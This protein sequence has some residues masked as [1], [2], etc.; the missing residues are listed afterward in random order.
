[1]RR[2]AIALAILLFAAAA[3]QSQSPAYLVKEINETPKPD[4]S[5]PDDFLALGNLAIFT[6]NDSQGNAL[7]VWRSDGSE[8]GTFLLGAGGN[9]LAIWNGRVWFT[10]PNG[11][12]VSSDGIQ[13]AQP[14][15]LPAGVSPYALMPSGPW[16]YFAAGDYLWRTD[17]TA[18]GTSKA[19]TETL[20][21]VPSTGT[22]LTGQ[23][24][25]FT[26][27]TPGSSTNSL[28]RAGAQVE[29]I[30]T[31]PAGTVPRSIGS[32]GSLVYIDLLT[33]ASNA[34]TLWR[35]DGTAAG[36]FELA[37]MPG[38]YVF[39]APY[40]YFTS[41][42][43]VWRSDGS[44]AGTGPLHASGFANG[45]PSPLGA[46]PDG[47][48]IVS[49]PA[50]APPNMNYTGLWSF[51]GMGSTFLANIPGGRPLPRTLGNLIVLGA[52]R[53]LWR[54]DGTVGG[55]YKLTGP[56]PTAG[57]PYWSFGVAGTSLFFNGEDAVHGRELW[58]TDGTVPNTLLVKDVNAATHPSYPTV[59]RALNGGVLFS[60]IGSGPD[61]P[62]PQRDLWFSDGT[63]AGTRKVLE[64][65]FVG[66][67]HGPLPCGRRAYFQHHS[68]ATGYELWSTD[69][70][71]LGTAIVKDIHPGVTG[72]EANSSSPQGFVC[73]DDRVLFFAGSATGWG[74]WRSD[75][76]AAGTVEVDADAGGALTPFGRGVFYGKN[77]ELWVS[78][79]TPGGTRSVT[80]LASLSSGLVVAGYHAWFTTYDNKLWRTDGT[81]A[82]TYP[83]P[84]PGSPFGLFAFGDRVVIR[85]GGDAPGYWS[86][87]GGAVTRFDHQLSASGAWE[88]FMR[89]LNGR[90]YYNVP[91]LRS[92]DGFTS[93]ATG[94][95][96]ADTLLAVA[97]GRLYYTQW[98]FGLPLLE[99]DGTAGGT[100]A[101]FDE[102]SSEA[103]ASGG[104]L[105]IGAK[106]LYAYD[107]PVTSTSI[108]PRTLPAGSGGQVVIH[109]RGFVA[110]V[111]VTVDKTPVSV[112]SVTATAIT[113]TAPPR[114]AGTYEVKLLTGDGREMTTDERLA[115]ACSPLTATIGATPPAVCPLT[116]VQLNG[117]G[118]SR[119]SWFPGTGLD[120]PSSCNPV[121]RAA[122]TTTYTLIVSDANACASTNH[123][124]VTV[125]VKP[126]PVAVITFSPPPPGGHRP[127]GTY[128]ASVP[129]G[130]PGTNYAWTI[131]G[132]AQLVGPA[133][134]RTVTFTTGCAYP[135]LSVIVTSAG[136]SASA[137]VN[138]G[139]S[140][141]I[142]IT[143]ISPFR[144]NAGATITVTGTSFQCV[145][146]VHLYDALYDRDADIPVT[147]SSETSVSFRL[148]ANAPPWAYVWM[149]GPFGYNINHVNYVLIRPLRDAFTGNDI[150]TDILTRNASTS[151]TEERGVSVNG[152]VAAPRP[153]V[154]PG[155]DYTIAAVHE[156]GLEM[157]NADVLWQRTST[158]ELLLQMDR[159]KPGT[160]VARVP[161]SDLAIAAV[162]D[163]D[164]NGFPELILRSTVTG[165]TELWTLSSTGAAV[166]VQPLHGGGNLGW[167]IIG[168]RDFD[169][170]GKS[171]L[172]W[173]D[174]N[175]GM[176]LIWLMNGATIRSSQIVH[177][178]GN[179]DWSIAA[180]GDFDADTKNDI[181][182]RHTPTG[183]TLLWRM[184]GASILQSS[185]VHPGGNLGWTIAGAGDFNGDSKSDIL[186]RESAQGTVLQWQMNGTQ[187]T[188]SAVVFPALDPA[189]KIESPR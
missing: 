117:G 17:G 173:R 185:V 118:G 138:L 60:A 166:T 96:D 125:T 152:A 169:G 137:S 46:L 120:N 167:K 62:S 183:M 84:L 89:P 105:F 158:R 161:A 41:G 104:R 122:T 15:P 154:D 146:T 186:W 12:L 171:D 180:L 168:S 110:P 112:V 64:R 22:A 65:V 177:Q 129:D 30:K 11:S 114:Q 165:A 163:H 76:T 142:E 160:V 21:V 187:I 95:P 141:P 101:I 32:T 28:W 24:A 23:S 56:E 159:T 149:S 75:G 35:T 31:F 97:G 40:L 188:K 87:D 66:D 26:V 27:T 94:A 108:A 29:H 33:Y 116:P 14:V 50:V 3:A 37:A 124:T 151:V 61:Y 113:F 57:Y 176:T 107:L 55:T 123:P 139:L 54:T 153:R 90:L 80:A 25:I 115:Y 34:S 130:G 77:Y 68:D 170:D 162:G 10:A 13:P 181:F 132:G 111:S 81:A 83:T 88:F 49:G 47:R 157:P 155:P 67:I 78:D 136:C 172:L 140:D 86:T 38:P 4:G 103:V 74:L 36:T 150:T 91:E 7:Q 6:T 79:G 174:A 93:V 148:P 53:E 19:S 18:A 5:S 43:L 147:P 69:G 102:R 63:S 92:T 70:T 82:G 182:W 20:W 73:V 45:I 189:V 156:F 39:G 59:L 16:L 98:A 9:T 135:L 99:T 131:A 126:K 2:V 145:T 85:M 133:N 72:A 164:G 100:R 44:V 127:G 52:T 106:E 178:G 184:D 1:M 179:Q 109:G 119:C 8:S 134:Q 144:A 48:V 128:T 143:G 51:D 42:M 175:N 71:V 58:K 121:A